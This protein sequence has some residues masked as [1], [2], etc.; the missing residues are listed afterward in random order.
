MLMIDFKEI[1]RTFS[2]YVEE[3]MITYRN[4]STAV[5]HKD[6][7]NDPHYGELYTNTSSRNFPYSHSFYML[8]TFY[9]C[10]EISLPQDENV[11]NYWLRGENIL[12]PSGVRQEAYN[13]VTFLHYPNQLLTSGSTIKF[14]WPKSREKMIVM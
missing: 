14:S 2:D 8:G 5:L 13:L 12:F 11:E 3:D 10:Y 7:Q 6:Y 4:G 1:M 9:Q